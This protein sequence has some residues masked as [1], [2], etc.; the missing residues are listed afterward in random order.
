[1]KI[2]LFIFVLFIGIFIT[3]ESFAATLRVGLKSNTEVMNMQQQLKTLGFYSGA[4]DGNFGQGT[5]KALVKFQLNNNLTADGIAGQKTQIILES[6]ITTTQ[7]SIPNK[8][9]TKNNIKS[10]VIP[11][12]NALGINGLPECMAS[13]APW[14][15][16]VNARTGGEKAIG[17]LIGTESKKAYMYWDG[18]NLPANA[19]I[20]LVSSN[21]TKIIPN[22]SNYFEY[23]P[24]LPDEGN[25][26]LV[27]YKN[28]GEVLAKDDVKFHITS[29]SN[30]I[31]NSSTCD[32]TNGNYITPSK[33][34]IY[35][36]V[37]IGVPFTLNWT[38]CGV[39]STTN[40]V[41][42]LKNDLLPNSGWKSSQ[43]VT[44]VNDGTETFTIKDTIPLGWYNILVSNKLTGASI[45]GFSIRI[46]K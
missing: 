34:P 29:V 12:P 15:R 25:G 42:R 41:M 22:N 36:D 28:N 37:K 3:Q 16:I 9:I 6:K 46:T 10:T 31:V 2:Y 40:L 7:I 19:T 44:I 8:N 1:M 38:S 32:T 23:I 45:G 33:W 4:I 43:S 5:K 18:C 14:I 21:E 24:S 17:F 11:V 27:V 39:P 26:S 35:T 13:S 20:K 30:N